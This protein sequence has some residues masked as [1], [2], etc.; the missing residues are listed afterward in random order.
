ML[1]SEIFRHPASCLWIKLFII[2]FL[3]TFLFSSDVASETS[4]LRGIVQLQRTMLQHN[5]NLLYIF[6]QAFS[7]ANRALGEG[8]LISFWHFCVAVA[9][10]IA[11]ALIAS[12]SRRRGGCYPPEIRVQTGARSCSRTW[13]GFGSGSCS[14]AASLFVPSGL[15]LDRHHDLFWQEF[16]KWNLYRCYCRLWCTFP[17]PQY[18]TYS[19]FT[20]CWLKEQ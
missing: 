20:K 7:T 19:C 11:F 13:A 10:M 3:N 12:H 14:T 5:R 4:A 2:Y 8:G 1:F 16:V 6:R 15:S 9:C 18:F 17:F